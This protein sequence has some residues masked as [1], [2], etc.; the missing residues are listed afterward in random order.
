MSLYKSLLALS[1][2]SPMKENLQLSDDY[3]GNRC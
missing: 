3:N 1:N 2:P